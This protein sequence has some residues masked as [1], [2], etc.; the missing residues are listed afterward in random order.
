MH[1][2]MIMLQEKLLTFASALYLLATPLY[3]IYLGKRSNAVGKAA[4][5]LG[6]IGA[7]L[8]TLGLVFR[9]WAAGINHPP[10][11]DL[12]ES[13]VF[14][15][16]GIV[17]FY[18]YMEWRHGVKMAGAFVF[19]IALA[20]M[21]LAVT[22]QEKGIMPLP[23]ALKSWWLHIHVMFASIAYAAFVVAFAFSLMYLIKDRVR[24]EMFGAVVSG[25][26]ALVFL[27][28]MIR[29]GVGY[30]GLFV[31]KQVSI[32]GG[33][34]VPRMIM[35]P[36]TGAREYTYQQ[37]PMVGPLF[38]GAM[39]ALALAALFYILRIKLENTTLDQAAGGA[40]CAATSL[41]TLGIILIFANVSKMANLSIK[42]EPF[43]IVLIFFLWLLAGG[44][45]MLHYLNAEITDRLPDVEKLDF[46]S[47]R[48][49]VVA[50][51]LMTIVIVT[52]AVWAQSAWG[53]YW[54][55]DPKETA[56]LVTWFVYAIYL[57]ARIVAGWK[58]RPAAIIS[59]IGFL[60]VIFTYLG[61]NVFLSGL[62][63]YAS[64]L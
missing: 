24:R 53:R 9:W 37:I 6:L 63:S 41:I 36:D 13:L 31:M 19:P 12:Y 28:I 15:G 47:Y 7:V 54:G 39:G 5:A 43:L 38:M 10:F 45:V 3:I 32:H 18:L 21:M 17:V 25:I 50:F 11:T 60:S 29:Q 14:F 56:S 23:D 48:S 16:W 33:E 35:N 55:W 52:G 1:D 42:G 22:H 2:T 49:V 61:V 59:I 51:P 44:M 58:G 34:I 26:V 27:L 30:L 4:T 46:L 40:L 20:A 64:S 62:H 8:N 57:H